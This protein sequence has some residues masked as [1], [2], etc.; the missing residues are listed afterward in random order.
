MSYFIVIAKLL[1][2]YQLIV[3]NVSPVTNFFSKEQNKL[4]ILMGVQRLSVD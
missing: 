1:L 2:L 4:K 3:R